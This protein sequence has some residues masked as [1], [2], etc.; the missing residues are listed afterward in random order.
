MRCCFAVNPQAGKRSSFR[1]LPLLLLLSY[2]HLRM[3]SEVNQA[4]SYISLAA[5][6]LETFS[7][8][9]SY[10]TARCCVSISTSSLWDFVWSLHS[11]LC[12][13]VSCSYPS[14]AISEISL[15][16]ITNEISQQKT[17]QIQ[18]DLNRDVFYPQIYGLISN[19]IIGVCSSSFHL[20]KLS[21]ILNRFLQDLCFELHLSCKIQPKKN[22]F[23]LW[24]VKKKPDHKY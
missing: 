20:L 9:P 16:N 10:Q 15:A 5:L 24:L 4:Q 3:T 6:P 14:K 23:Y 13:Y 17:D 8:P 2:Q 18:L 21:K 19:Q 7:P 22:C 11:R 1:S 12:A